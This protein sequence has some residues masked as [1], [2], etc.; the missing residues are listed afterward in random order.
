LEIFIVL[1]LNVEPTSVL[2]RGAVIVIVLTHLALLS[3]ILLLV[4]VVTRLRVERSSLEALIA[5]HALRL[6]DT[7]QIKLRLRSL[8]LGIKSGY[9]TRF[10]RDEF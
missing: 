1:D 5:S 10:V 7:L 4:I 2:N 3:G 9:L 6:E 8:A